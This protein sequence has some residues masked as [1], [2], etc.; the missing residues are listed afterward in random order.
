MTLISL[1]SSVAIEPV[2]GDAEQHHPA[3]LSVASYTVT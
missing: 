1:A 2:L 3:Q